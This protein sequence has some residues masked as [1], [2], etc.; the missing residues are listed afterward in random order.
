MSL[1]SFI[2]NTI[3]ASDLLTPHQRRWLYEWFNLS[4]GRAWIESH[5]FFQQPDL[6]N[7]RLGTGVFLNHFCS[8]DNSE[9]IKIGANT[10]LGSYVKLLTT[11]H[12][13]GFPHSSHGAIRKPIAIGRDC[14]L[15]CGVIV[16]PGVTIGDR[17]TVGA[18]AV[19]T[20]DLPSDDTYVGVPAKRLSSGND[21]AELM[22]PLSCP[23]V[24]MT[25]AP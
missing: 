24:P 1:K 6:F 17:V 4:L 7:V 23:S 20:C 2:I 11:T 19:V 13:R 5:C 12:D 21:R 18:G 22:Q 9:A 10:R 14:W 25:L 15:G 3:A 16:L 8:L